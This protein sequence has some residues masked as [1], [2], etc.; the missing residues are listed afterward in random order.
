MDRNS[1]Y[2]WMAS[3]SETQTEIQTSIEII[4]NMTLSGS[5]DLGS[6]IVK[7]STL[8]FG[9]VTL[10]PKEEAMPKLFG[11]FKD[12]CEPFLT[13]PLSNQMASSLRDLCLRLIYTP[14]APT[15]K[16]V[17]VRM[18]VPGSGTAVVSPVI[19]SPIW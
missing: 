3:I 14:M 15:A 16:V 18:S 8:P 13:I 19:S 1:Q 17:A 9:V 12:M 11:R 7:K 5:L 10:S 4:R 2:F 6:Q